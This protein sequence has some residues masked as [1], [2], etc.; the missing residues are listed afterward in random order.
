MPN[1]EVPKLSKKG[2]GFD[3]IWLSPSS[4][5]LFRIQMDTIP[6]ITLTL[7][8]MIRNESVKT[9]EGT[10]KGLAAERDHS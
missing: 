7:V 1:A 6:T 8:I 2:D 10:A 4:K 5:L 3:S 9:A